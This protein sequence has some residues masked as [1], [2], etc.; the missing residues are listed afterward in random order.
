MKLIWS[1]QSIEDRKQIYAVIAEHDQ[2]AADE[3][4]VLFRKQATLLLSF[5]EMGK[6]GRVEGT[7]ELLA[8]KHYVLVYVRAG[9]AVVILTIL[10]TSRQ[11]PV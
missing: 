11:Y 9:N 2:R 4:D 8:H 6:L 3:M 1:L 5:P 7:R 10:H